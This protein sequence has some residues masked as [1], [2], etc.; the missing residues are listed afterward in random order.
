M[1]AFR[2]TCHQVVESLVKISGFN[3]HSVTS[4]KSRESLSQ[5]L[6]RP[7]KQYGALTDVSDIVGIRI[8][9]YF[10]DE[11]TCLG[12]SAQSKLESRH[13]DLVAGCRVLRPELA[14]CQIAE[15]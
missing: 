3:V 2:S 7:G 13:P 1:D 11:V 8:V 14:R 12:S 4:L 5:K 9:A 6:A 10:D 15:A